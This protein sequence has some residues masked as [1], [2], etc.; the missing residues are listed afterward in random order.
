MPLR[1]FGPGKTG[2]FDDSGVSVCQV[3]KSGVMYL[4][5]NLGTTVKF[6][7]TLAHWNNHQRTILRQRDEHV[8]SV[9][10]G[11]IDDS[12]LF[13]H[14]VTDWPMLNTTLIGEPGMILDSIMSRPCVLG[15]E[16]WYS[17]RAQDSQ[18][19]IG[20][21]K[22][23]GGAWAIEPSGIEPSGSG[24]DSDAVTYPCVFDWEGNRY[25][26]YNGNGYGKTGFGLAILEA[27]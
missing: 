22:L 9:S 18:Y 23:K 7:N 26:L 17:Y 14:V 25:C 13:Y 3:S 21:A 27:S 12:R 20:Y 24:F 4:G 11:W 2:S 8:I 1:L 5:W 16:M 19:R 6:R 15:D 10:Y